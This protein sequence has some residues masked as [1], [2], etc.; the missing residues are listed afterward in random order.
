MKISNTGE[1]YWIL[2]IGI[3]LMAIAYAM[4][5]WER[6]QKRKDAD[7]FFNEYFKDEGKDKE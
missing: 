4:R 3:I 7:R 5:V 1:T 2:A 6:R